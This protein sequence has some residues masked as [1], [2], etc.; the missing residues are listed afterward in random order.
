MSEKYTEPAWR[1]AFYR[2]YDKAR[3]DFE[4]SGA[5]VCPTVAKALAASMSWNM[6][7]FCAGPCGDCHQKRSAEEYP[8]DPCPQ[9]Q[10]GMTECSICPFD[11]F[12]RLY[13]LQSEQDS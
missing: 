1:I 7:D 6:C 2:W 4:N 10:Y 8:C 12:R 11:L 3:L 5:E 13:R 9:D